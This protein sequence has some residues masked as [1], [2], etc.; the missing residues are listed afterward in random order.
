MTGYGVNLGTFLLPRCLCW[1]TSTEQGPLKLERQ[2]HIVGEV[3][4]AISSIWTSA[5]Y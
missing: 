1:Q 4:S 2:Q 5:Q 3:W